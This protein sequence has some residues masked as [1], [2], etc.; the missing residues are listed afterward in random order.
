MKQYK[1]V[2]NGLQYEVEIKEFA[3]SIAELE[4]NGTPFR[5]EVTHQPATTKTPRPKRPAVKSQAAAAAPAAAPTGGGPVS[6]VTSPLPGT[7]LQVLV[8]AGDTVKK[9]DKLLVM[10][11]MKME[12]NIQ[13]ERD[14]II[15]SIKVAVGDNVLQGAA[16][17]EIE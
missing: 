14:G 9:G 12:N 10:E 6:Q 1:F 13:S 11:A 8:K 16:L 15:K 7:V 3:D 17:L 4:V 2:I 5:V